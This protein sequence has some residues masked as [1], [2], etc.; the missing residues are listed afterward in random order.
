MVIGL[1]EPKLG[2][3][4]TQMGKWPK[5]GPCVVLEVRAAL[6][7]RFWENFIKQNL[8][9]NIDL[10]GVGQVSTSPAPHPGVQQQVQVQGEGLLPWSLGQ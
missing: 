4:V 6:S 8:Y 2:R 10:V 7:V 9:R 5:S 1:I 3:C